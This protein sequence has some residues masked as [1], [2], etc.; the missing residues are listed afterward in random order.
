MGGEY[1]NHH[2][3]PFTSRHHTPGRLFT[4]DAGGGAAHDG[5]LGSL[6]YAA[7]G[8]RT[9][10][11]DTEELKTGYDQAYRDFYRWSAIV[12]ASLFHGS[13]KHQAKHFFYTSGWKKFEPLWN[14][15]IQ[16][17]RSESDDAV[18]G[19]GAIESDWGKAGAG[20]ER[21][22]ENRFPETMESGGLSHA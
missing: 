13:A 6:R 3:R 7:R 22:K 12:R 1:G 14:M 19:R 9:R 17:K 21:P 20:S 18:A 5:Q 4:K 15:M 16:M 11:N 8:L 2:S 10:R